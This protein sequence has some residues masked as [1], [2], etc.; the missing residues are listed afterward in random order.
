[1]EA[2]GGNGYASYDLGRMY[3]L[4]LGCDADEEEAQTWFRSALETF[5]KAEQ[6]AE[7]KGYLRYR[8][9]KCHEHDRNRHRSGF[10][11]EPVL[12]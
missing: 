11:K 2:R 3:L 5:Q 10:G 6:T 1:M 12:F 7:K 4:G 8:I 9:G